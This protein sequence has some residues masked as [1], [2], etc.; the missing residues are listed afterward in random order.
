MAVIENPLR[1]LHLESQVI[2]QLL[3]ALGLILPVLDILMGGR[4]AGEEE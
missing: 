1:H 2:S 3:L 4:R